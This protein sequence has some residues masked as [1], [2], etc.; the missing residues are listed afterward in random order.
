[1]SPMSPGVSRR[2][3]EVQERVAVVRRKD[4]EKPFYD[5]APEGKGGLDSEWLVQ[6][7]H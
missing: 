4:V 2:G 1:M 5:A 7:L 6:C 3:R